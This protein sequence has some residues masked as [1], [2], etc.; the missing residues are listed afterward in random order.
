MSVATEFMRANRL[1]A[2]IVVAYLAFALLFAVRTPDWQAPDEPAHYNYIAQIAQR[3]CCPMIEPGDWDEAY[4][5]QLKADNFAPALLADLTAVQYED[6]QPPLYYLALTPLYR[7]TNGSLIAL[8]LASAALGLIVVGCTYVAARQWRPGQPQIALAAA[9]LVAFLPQYLGITA[10]VNNDALAWALTG[11]TLVATLHHLRDTNVNETSGLRA[12]AGL[13]LLVGLGLLTKVST[14]LLLAVVPFAL[15]LRWRRTGAPVRYLVGG[16][17]VFGLVALALAGLW[18]LRNLGVY[19]V[20][21][22]LGLAAHDRVVVGQLRTETLIAQV[23]VIEYLRRALTTT[24]NSFFGQLGW[25]ALPLP[26]WVYVAI[27]L[28]LLL[29]IA[30]W[31]A[32]RD[33]VG[34]TQPSQQHVTLVLAF[35]GLLAIMQYLYY[36][37][38]FVQFQGRYLFTGLIPFALFVAQGGDG[39][40]ARLWGSNSLGSYILVG[41]P[42]LLI[43]LDL[44]LLWRVIPGLAP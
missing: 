2:V 41:L 44:W 22:F 29:A 35:A 27:G 13:G 43:P 20:P 38:E 17:A 28:L 30:G 3:G 36:N 18:W 16:L 40:R 31:F 42:L 21:D 1:F 7:L 24:F 37:T 12:A 25:M 32:R 23:G 15:F 8:R 19:G 5:D 26:G 11:L 14:L 10:S 6:H 39:W 9:A 4:L 33:A 34:Q